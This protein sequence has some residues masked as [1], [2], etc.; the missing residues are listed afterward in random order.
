MC[1]RDTLDFLPVLLVMKK[2]PYVGVMGKQSGRIS[3]KEHALSM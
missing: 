2:K 1:P 3:P